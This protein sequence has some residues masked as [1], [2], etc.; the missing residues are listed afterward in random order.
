[1]LTSVPEL[2]PTEIKESSS[3]RSAKLPTID[4]PPS[5]PQAKSARKSSQ[6]SIWDAF[7]EIDVPPQS[8]DRPKTTH[9]DSH[10][11]S[12]IEKQPES[13]S[14][15]RTRPPR[16]PFKEQALPDTR[17]DSSPGPSPP[18]R[19]LHRI[20]SPALTSPAKSKTRNAEAIV[21][22]N[23]LLDLE[24]A[25]SGDEVSEGS[26]SVS[27]EMDDSDRQFLHELPETQV[28]PSYNQTLVYR[29]S[30]MSQAPDS[31][32]RPV[33]TTKPLRRGPFGR[34]VPN[35]K[36]NVASSSPPRADS[37]EDTYAVGTFVVHDDAE[38]SYEGP[39]SDGLQE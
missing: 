26:S 25:H 9:P 19:R 33:F 18:Q 16:R 15:L 5:P 17:L 13:S 38:L 34:L 10:S 35:V 39:S 23:P 21:G 8:T 6:S 2:S 32:K 20:L 29:E 24:A 3:E 1:V 36:R 37:L 28:S 27:E 30:L 11:N 31:S 7:P 14:P 12:T 4:S 22:R